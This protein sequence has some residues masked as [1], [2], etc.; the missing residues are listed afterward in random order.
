MNRFTLI[1]R[2]PLPVILTGCTAPPTKEYR[3]GSPTASERTIQQSGV[4]IALDPF[5][6]RERTK[7]YFDIDAI[8]DGI[9]I[10][11]CVSQTKPPI[12]HS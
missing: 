9:A 8:A 4:E 1:A 10:L 3:P 12:K 2:A 11:H 6:K 7:Q 5:V